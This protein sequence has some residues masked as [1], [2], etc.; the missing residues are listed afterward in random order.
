MVNPPGWRWGPGTVARLERMQKS[1][2]RL[3]ASAAP[4]AVRECVFSSAESLVRA[5][6]GRILCPSSIGT[7]FGKQMRPR[8][9]P[10]GRWEFSHR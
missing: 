2:R 1:L 9:D 3:P 5:A 6:G 8:I 4:R 7:D 10:K